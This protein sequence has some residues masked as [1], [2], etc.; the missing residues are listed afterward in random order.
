MRGVR[1][2]GGGGRWA[3]MRG[4]VH[5]CYRAQSVYKCTSDLRSLT[6]AV[7]TSPQTRLFS[8]EELPVCG[9]GPTLTYRKQSKPNLQER[10]YIIPL[11][12]V[13]LPV[14]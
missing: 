8:R 1:T 13:R 5:V 2:A 7:A 12:R 4:V 3:P 10:K 6:T 14:V 9:H 11:Q